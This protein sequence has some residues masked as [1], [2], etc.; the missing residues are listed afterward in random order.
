MPLCP[1]GLL[2]CPALRCA[3]PH[4]G[5]GAGE[6]ASSRPA[7]TLH[8]SP[9]PP[10]PCIIVDA[11]P[12]LQKSACTQ[13]CLLWKWQL[14]AP[15]HPCAICLIPQPA[16]HLMRL[17]IR[18]CVYTPWLPACLRAACCAG[19]RCSSEQT[20]EANPRAFAII[21]AA[22]LTGLFTFAVFLGIVTDEVKTT[23]R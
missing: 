7:R 23:F 1:C 18:T 8:C 16:V 5:P 19:H 13:E 4:A 14:H 10:W 22:F 15:T 6:G 3:E 21:N 11:H 2:H 9:V 17:Q 12:L 20:N